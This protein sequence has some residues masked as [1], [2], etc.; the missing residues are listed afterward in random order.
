MVFGANPSATPRE[1]TTMTTQD[2]DTRTLRR[3]IAA[4]SIGNFVEWF[5]FAAYGFLATIL[6]RE[7]FPERRSDDRAAE[8]VRRVCGGVRVPSARRPGVRRDRRPDR[9]QAHA[10]ADDPDDGRVDDADRPAATYASIGY[11]APLLLTIIRC[12]Q[13]FSAGGEYAGACA[14]VMEHA[15]RRRRAFFGSFVRSRRSRRS[16]ARPWSRICSNRRCR[17]RR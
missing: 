3:V 1:D 17:R 2:V 8:D 16:R 7:F 4:A 10:R 11:W 12:V 13:G 9:P 15:P 6:T 14:Y 5:D